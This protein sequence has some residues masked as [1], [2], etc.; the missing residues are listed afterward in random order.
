MGFSKMKNN[1]QPNFGRR[2][3]LLCVEYL[4]DSLVTM[5]RRH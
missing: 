5:S 4:W 3:L 2:V 1:G